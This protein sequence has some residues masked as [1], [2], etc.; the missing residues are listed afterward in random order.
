MDDPH[1]SVV[2]CVSEYANAEHETTFYLPCIQLANLQRLGLQ[3]V[4]GAF[5]STLML[6]ETF[7]FTP[8]LLRVWGA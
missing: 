1:Y 4:D 6:A 2:M 3:H 8:V 5:M 7:H